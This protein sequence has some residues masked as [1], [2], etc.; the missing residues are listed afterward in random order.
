[1]PYKANLIRASNGNGVAPACPS[2]CNRRNVEPAP[3]SRRQPP[4]RSPLLPRLPAGYIYY[5]VEQ[6]LQAQT[7]INN[8]AIVG[9]EQRVSPET[10]S[11]LHELLRKAKRGRNFDRTI[12]VF[13]DKRSPGF[14]WLIDGWLGEKRILSMNT[15]KWVRLSKILL[16]PN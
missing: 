9:F 12:S 5:G 3:V 16:H 11:T 4:L 14:Q 13:Y 10:L 15:H 7:S 8:G 1:M 2:N 6:N